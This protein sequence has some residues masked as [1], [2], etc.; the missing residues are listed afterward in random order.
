MIV[1]SL[2]LVIMLALLHFFAERIR[3]FRS[4]P[5]SSLLSMASGVSVA[6]V[7]VHIFPKLSAYQDVLVEQIHWPVIEHHVYLMSLLGFCAFYG[8]E[9]AVQRR[10][11]GERA[12]ESAASGRQVFWVHLGVFALYYA[13]IGYLLIHREQEGWPEL[14]MYALA[15]GLHFTVIDVGL[16]RHH[17]QAYHVYG[18]WILSGSVVAGWVIGF[19]GSLAQAIIGALFA[20]LAGGIILN[21]IKEELPAERSSRLGAFVV[22]ALGFG[23]LLLLTI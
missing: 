15:M 9:R 19:V 1:L 8:V 5:R 4:V 18:R 21:A 10:G 20:F 12:L 22:G 2:F 14:V 3:F 17:R 13:L 11:N 23:A 7:F 16:S 6:Y